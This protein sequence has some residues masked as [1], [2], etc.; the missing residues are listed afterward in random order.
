[1][2]LIKKTANAFFNSL[3]IVSSSLSRK[4]LLNV[5]HK[6]LLHYFMWL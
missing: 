3:S 6:L 5:S 2:K 1:M 4:L